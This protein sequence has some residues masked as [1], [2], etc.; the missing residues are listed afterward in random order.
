MFGS[1]VNAQSQADRVK[2]VTGGQGTVQQSTHQ[3][4][5]VG[6]VFG[7]N[8]PT[9][10]NPQTG[11]LPSHSAYTGDLTTSGSDEPQV[12]LPNFITPEEL[13]QR[14]DEAWGAGQFS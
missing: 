2:T 1:P 14:I 9:G 13:K 12:Q 10:G 11:A 3:K 7:N 4:D 8:P 5:F 6:T